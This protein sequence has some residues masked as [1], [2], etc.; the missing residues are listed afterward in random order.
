MAVALYL[1]KL[2]YKKNIRILLVYIALNKVLLAVAH[3]VV[4]NRVPAGAVLCAQQPDAH[5]G[6]VDPWRWRDRE[7]LPQDLT[8]AEEPVV[9]A[10]LVAQHVQLV[11]L[12]LHLGRRLLAWRVGLLA[13]PQELLVLWSMG[14]ALLPAISLHR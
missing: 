4:A 2:K 1:D 9:L 6:V 11:G 8:A 10:V 5:V 7:L 3:K 12:L 14:R 13:R